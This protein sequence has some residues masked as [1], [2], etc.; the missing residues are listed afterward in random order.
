MILDHGI[1]D[2][3][4]MTSVEHKFVSYEI[5]GLYI[6]MIQKNLDH[7]KWFTQNLVIVL[8]LDQ[9]LEDNKINPPPLNPQTSL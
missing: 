3:Y 8:R 2:F 1:I 9:K 4:N 6:F 7:E 5:M